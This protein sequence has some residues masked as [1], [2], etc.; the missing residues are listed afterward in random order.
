MKRELLIKSHV[1]I[2]EFFK[3]IIEFNSDFSELDKENLVDY[4]LMRDKYVLVFK[5]FLF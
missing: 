5:Y 1:L 4:C 2:D 3:T